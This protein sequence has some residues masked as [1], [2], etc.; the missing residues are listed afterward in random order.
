MKPG[1]TRATAAVAAVIAASAV[2]YALRPSPQ[3]ATAVAQR[4]PAVEVRTVVIRRTIHIVRHERPRTPPV[5]GTTPAASPGYVAG[6]ATAAT[7]P[8]TT[9][10]S[11]GRTA[12]AGT[13]TTRTSAAAGRLTTRTS[14]GHG[15]D[16]GSDGGGDD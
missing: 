15:D 11:A 12:A 14:S 4:T 1:Q 8:V 6:G 9:R 16:G 2:V 7:R 5:G 3:Q 10:T 13:L